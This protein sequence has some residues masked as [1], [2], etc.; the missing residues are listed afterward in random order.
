MQAPAL[1]SM[2]NLMALQHGWEHGEAGISISLHFY[3][4]LTDQQTALIRWKGAAL[5]FLDRFERDYLN[6]SFIAQLMC[7]SVIHT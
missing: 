4:S 2:R 3:H 1:Q 7:H 6:P 5:K